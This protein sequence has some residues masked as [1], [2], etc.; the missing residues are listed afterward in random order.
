MV[1]VAAVVLIGCLWLALLIA[2]R[3]QRLVVREHER[4]P[5]L[6]E[7]LER[8][9][10]SLRRPAVLIGAAGVAALLLIAPLVRNPSRWARL[11]LAL[12]ALAVVVAVVLIRRRRADA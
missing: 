7:A 8:M 9:R 10:T 2:R 1:V 4:D 5:E 6:D 12:G 3:Q 11:L